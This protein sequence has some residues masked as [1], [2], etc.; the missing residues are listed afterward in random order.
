MKPGGRR[1]GKAGGR[2][3]NTSY[4]RALI[5]R[6]RS[7]KHVPRVRTPKRR[8]R[9]VADGREGPGGTKVRMGRPAWLVTKKRRG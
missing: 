9:G 5:D 7:G 4:R 6:T 1:E 8:C 2:G 3:P